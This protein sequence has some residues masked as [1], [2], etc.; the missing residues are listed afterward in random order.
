[1]STSVI[2]VSHRRHE[3][4]SPCLE[5]V[6]DQCDELVVVDNGSPGATV[7]ETARAAG[8]RPVRLAGNVGFPAGVNAGAR[9]ARGEVVA[10]LND[11][12]MAEPGWLKSA[13]A[14]LADPGVAAVAPKLVFALPHAEL[15]FDDEPKRVG[16]DPRPLGRR[17][18]SA[19]VAG[20]DVLAALVGPG[21]HALEHGVVDGA[22]ATWRWTA[23]ALPVYLPLRPGWDVAD[24]RIDGEPAP[25]TGR[26]QLVNNAGSYLSREGHIGDY[27]YLAP[28]DGRFDEPGE[29]FAAC[30]AALV[31]TAQAL[32]RVGDFAGG[33]FAYYEDGDWSWRAQLAGLRVRY[34]PEGVVR[35]VGG[36]S[37]G[38]P[39]QQ[40]V[41][42]LAARNRILCLV[43]NAPVPVA[44]VQAARALRDRSLGPVR[45]SLARRLPAAAAQRPVLARRWRRRPDDVWAQWAGVGEEW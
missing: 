38:G 24:L 14:V 2:V 12:A 37:S 40:V 45:R 15:R 31:T 23:G 32:A 10:L 16:A 11:D 7:S 19:A 4:L 5:S 13:E 28:D 36:V 30:G 9:V 42:D 44:A 1:M 26:V 3:W 21:V 41:K 22:P 43:R 33:F 39:L 18:G 35:H 34:Q 25:V 29:R 6:R 27:G 20:A 17:L 8:A